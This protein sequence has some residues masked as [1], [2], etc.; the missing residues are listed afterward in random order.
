M[1]TFLAKD[2][3]MGLRLAKTDREAFLEESDTELMEQYGRIITEYV[4]VP[5]ILLEDTVTL[6]RYLQM[7]FDHVWTFNPKSTK[8]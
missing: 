6:S 5:D 1:F 3:T 2:G 8:R 4:Q 7:S